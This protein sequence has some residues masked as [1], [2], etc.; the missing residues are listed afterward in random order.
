MDYKATARQTSIQTYNMAHFIE[1]RIFHKFIAKQ[2]KIG[3]NLS[4]LVSTLNIYQLDDEVIEEFLVSCIRPA[5]R[6]GYKLTVKEGLSNFHQVHEKGS[7]K[8]LKTPGRNGR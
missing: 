2:K 1:N 5:M 7:K 6:E 4:S 3:S 8:P